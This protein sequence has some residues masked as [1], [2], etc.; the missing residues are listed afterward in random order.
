MDLKYFER[1]L[2]EKQLQLQSDVAA[3]EGEARDAGD[4][5][6]SDT[7]DDA[8]ADESTSQALE[9]G[10]VISQTLQRVES[11]LQRIK[12]GTYGRCTICGRQI[13]PARLEAVP[14]AEYCVEDQE[15]LDKVDKAAG[16]VEGSTL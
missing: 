5:D 2:L 12:D 13:P 4:V 3:F 16:P 14:W 6:V 8:A 1:K 10:G 7:T 15:K 11:A 9:E